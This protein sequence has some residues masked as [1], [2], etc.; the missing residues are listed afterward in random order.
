MG[1]FF[2]SLNFWL[3]FK[4][5]KIHSTLYWK[6]VLQTPK[7]FLLAILSSFKRW[8]GHSLTNVLENLIYTASLQMHCLFSH[9]PFFLK[10]FLSS[11]NTKLNFVLSLFILLFWNQYR[12]YWCYTSITTTNYLWCVFNK[13]IMFSMH[14]IN[15]NTPRLL[16][17]PCHWSNNNVVIKPLKMKMNAKMISQIFG[18][19]MFYIRLIWSRRSFT[20]LSW[21]TIFKL[22]Q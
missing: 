3:I 5:N 18:N 1:F 10:M 6:K 11:I 12:F 4:K 13:C 21:F 19:H 2:F 8:N 7:E 17:F 15:L 16:S 9:K 20:L 14:F 22:S